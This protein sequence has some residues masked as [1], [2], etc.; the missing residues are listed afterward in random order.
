M[1][2]LAYVD[3]RLGPLMSAIDE[4]V[5]ATFAALI[6]FV[7]LTVGVS[8]MFEVLLSSWDS[9]APP[10]ATS[11]GWGAQEDP[12]AVEA[13]AAWG[14]DVWAEGFQQGQFSRW[15]IPWF[16]MYGHIAPQARYISRHISP[17]ISPLI[18]RQPSYL[19]SYLAS[20][21]PSHL[22]LRPHLAAG[23]HLPA[24]HLLHRAGG[25][26]ALHAHRAG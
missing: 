7:L 23:A 21:L 17:Q 18:S 26:L 2:Q 25:A 16:A 8:I 22:A 14:A 11:S 24:R 20:H 4:M 6:I 13:G 19:A 15:T 1:L 9:D 5:R 12:A 3:A 10:N